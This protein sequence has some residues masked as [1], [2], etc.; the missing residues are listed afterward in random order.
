[1]KPRNPSYVKPDTGEGVPKYRLSGR[2]ILDFL[3][4]E[5]DPS[6]NLLGNRWLTKGSGV[7]IVAPSGHGNS[8][9]ATQILISFAIGRP[10]FGIKPPRAL[11][12]LCI[13][14]EDDDAETKKFAQ[15]IRTMNL[16]EKE[17]ELL[18]SNTR[19]EFRNDLTGHE[20]IE[21]LNDF[22]TEFPADI[23]IINPIT[24]FFL[25]D[26]KDDEKVARFLRAELN[27][28]LST[29]SCAAILIH[30]TPKTN[31]TKLENMKWYDW[32]YAMSGCATLTNWS[33][34]VLVVAPSK[35]PGTYR[36][37]AAKRFDEIQ[38]VEREYW[39]SHSRETLKTDSRDVDII[40]WIPS[41]EE[42]I[43]SAGPVASNARKTVLPPE[44]VWKKMSSIREFTRA[45]FAEWVRE[46]FSG[47]FAAGEKRAF[48]ILDILADEG[49][50][51][52]SNQKRR[53][54]NDLKVYRKV[55]QSSSVNG[56][57]DNEE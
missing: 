22:L 19:F 10:A 42:Q 39:F 25:A 12:I 50:A 33:R 49:L 6:S 21:A 43:R 31:F 7:F 2:N 52:V 8:S 5:I 51:E 15:I 28:V 34:A 11:R 55:C 18:K 9:M 20:F 41:T 45:T 13:Q 38:W 4:M 56:S 23:V 44:T 17:A 3:D 46:E 54:T 1:M 53:G 16:S 47:Q 40:Q 36:F 57:H 14:S 32:M 29:H 26:L 48:T 35:V 27:K 24:G 37:I 30:H